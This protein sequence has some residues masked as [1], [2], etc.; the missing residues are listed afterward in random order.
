MCVYLQ[1]LRLKLFHMKNL[2]KT[3][4]LAKEYNFINDISKYLS[5]SITVYFSEA[6]YKYLCFAYVCVCVCVCTFSLLQHFDLVPPHLTEDLHLFSLNDLTAVRSGDLAPKLRDLVR[7]GSE[8]VASCVV[9]D[10][11]KIYM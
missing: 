11:W 5:M 7:A 6:R 1:V 2:F 9:S 3:C 10:N 4:R 8:H